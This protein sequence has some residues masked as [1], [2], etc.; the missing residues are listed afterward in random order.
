[1]ASKIPLEEGRNLHLN[2]VVK[3]VSIRILGAKI[4][5]NS[6]WPKLEII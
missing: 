5:T 1:M 4:G 6:E 2:T 3:E